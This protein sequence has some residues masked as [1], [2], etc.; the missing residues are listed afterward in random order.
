MFYIFR[1]V[2][3]VTTELKC[4]ENW[5][6]KV[7]LIL[8]YELCRLRG[9]R[10]IYLVGL[11]SS[12]TNV[13]QSLKCSN[14]MASEMLWQHLFIVSLSLWDSFINENRISCEFSF[15]PFS[16]VVILITF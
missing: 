5:K 10:A 1:S 3:A 8:D 7:F 12:V 11:T 6:A 2:T 16:E 4:T 13:A 9:R 14:L 15:Q